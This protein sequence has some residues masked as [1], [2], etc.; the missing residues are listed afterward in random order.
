M[1]LA[2]L[3]GIVEVLCNEERSL[4]ERK[5]IPVCVKN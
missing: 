3:V 2:E 4:D 1:L 5:N